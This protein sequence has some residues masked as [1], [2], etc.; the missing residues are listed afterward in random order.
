MTAARFASTRPSDEP[1]RS[2]YFDEFDGFD[3]YIDKQPID[4]DDESRIHD[5]KI[6]DSDNKEPS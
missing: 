6:R 4:P 5:N 1:M 3:P 2:R